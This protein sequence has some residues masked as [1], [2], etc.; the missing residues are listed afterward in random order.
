MT[1][2][3]TSE[4]DS[5]LGLIVSFE[6]CIASLI[7]IVKLSFSRRKFKK[8]YLRVVAHVF[9]AAQEAERGGSPE[10]GKSKLQSAM[11]AAWQS[12]LGNRARLCL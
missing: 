6:N 4:S 3:N 12:S 1:I 5:C 2:Y 11:I 10:P 9:P 7:N 8:N